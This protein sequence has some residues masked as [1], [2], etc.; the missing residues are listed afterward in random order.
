MNGS[1][2]TGDFDPIG[3][4]F[5][6]AQEQKGSVGFSEQEYFE[7]PPAG[8][9]KLRRGGV[10]NGFVV[11]VVCQSTARFSNGR[12]WKQFSISQRR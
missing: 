6:L 4:M 3:D 1:M 12:P 8:F 7:F 11:D 2:P 5:G 9:V 10:Q